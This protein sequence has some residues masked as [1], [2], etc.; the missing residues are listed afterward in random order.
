MACLQT[1]AAHDP[2]YINDAA[3]PLDLTGIPLVGEG[4]KRCVC[5]FPGDPSYLIKVVRPDRHDNWA[6]P[7]HRWKHLIYRVGANALF[8]DELR[9]QF[10]LRRHGPLPDILA[11]IVGL[12]ETSLGLGVVVRAV[13]NDDGT[14]ARDVFQFI[15]DG[16]YDDEVE[17]ALNVFFEELLSS[18]IVLSDLTPSNICCARRNGRL[19]LVLVDGWGDDSLLRLKSLSP[20]FNR[21]CKRG[22]IARCWRRIRKERALYAKSSAA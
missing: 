1:S 13:R 7:P 20:R 8:L 17:S 2:G 3:K 21:M 22:A 10:A 15:H 12:V 6:R 5:V 18:P 16:R 4:T 9:E 11:P 19:H 14:T